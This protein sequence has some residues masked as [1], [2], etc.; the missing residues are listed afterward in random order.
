[1]RGCVARAEA[2]M[3]D[4]KIETLDQKAWL[5]ETCPCCAR[6][7]I[8]NCADCGGTGRRA[9]HMHDPASAITAP[10]EEE[11]AADLAISMYDEVTA[12]RDALR[13]NIKSL[14][15]AFELEK[16]EHERTWNHKKEMIE[17]RDAISEE[18]TRLRDWNERAD[19]VLS[20][21]GDAIQSDPG[22]MVG[23]Y[24]PARYRRVVDE[25]TRLKRELTRTK[26]AL[27]E[28]RR[29]WRESCECDGASEQTQLL[30]AQIE[31]QALALKEMEADR[32]RCEEQCAEAE[33]EL[34]T[35]NLRA[36][37]AERARDSARDDLRDEIDGAAPLQGRLGQVMGE[38]SSALEHN[39]ALHQRVEELKDRSRARGDALQH[40]ID[41]GPPCPLCGAED[42]E[43]ESAGMYPHHTGCIGLTLLAGTIPE[44]RSC[45]CPSGPCLYLNRE[46]P[47]SPFA[48]VGT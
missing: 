31:Q 14:R 46:H 47:R 21:W 45:W 37:A 20:D 18:N 4:E 17:S 12:E 16:R 35:E 19:K 33:R 9:R 24:G 8:P 26:E 29:E 32:D 43:T 30:R 40:C 42:E 22:V 38:L 6:G 34:N 2:K 10:T 44:P 36:I 11:K 5:A 1:M 48:E 7:Y 28:V 15:E 23:D 3:S 25:N 39:R 13:V 27:A 41:L